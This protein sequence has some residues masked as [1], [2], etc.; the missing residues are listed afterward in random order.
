MVAM[1]L[2]QLLIH[3]REDR[4]RDTHDD[5]RRYR[6]PDGVGLGEFPDGENAKDGARDERC[7]D[8]D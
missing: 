3:K 1:A 7:G 6:T 4:G 5:E 2:T 8:H